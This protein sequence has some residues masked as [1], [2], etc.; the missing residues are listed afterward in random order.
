MNMYR[1]K[2]IDR[3]RIIKL[4]F[5]AV[6]CG[7]VICCMLSLTKFDAQSRSIA[8][9]VVR[10]H[11][12]ANSNSAEDQALKLHVRNLVQELCYNMYAN[13]ETRSEAEALIQKRLPYIVE[14]VQ[15]EIQKMG[16]DYKINGELVNMYF[17]NRTYGSVTL[18]AGYYHAVRLTIG[19]GKGHNWWC[20]MYPPICISCAEKRADIS[21]V[22]DEEQTK[23]VTEKSY[24]YEFKVY[25]LYRDF[26]NKIKAAT[27]NRS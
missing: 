16:Y 27:E 4:V 13:A 25:E 18:P 8:D 23:V 2:S 17:T 21:D 1:R 15:D 22:L 5:R 24:K 3:L 6:L 20:V 19:E 10:L 14:N 11:I 9:S 12:L 26:T 7:F